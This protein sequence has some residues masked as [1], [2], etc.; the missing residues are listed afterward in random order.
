MITKTHKLRLFTDHA[1]K[2]ITRLYSWR[3]AASWT[4]ATKKKTPAA[5]DTEVIFMT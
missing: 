1:L 5:G 4:G 2:E 3:G